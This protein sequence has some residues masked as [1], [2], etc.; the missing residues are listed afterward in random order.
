MLNLSPS[1]VLFP[2]QYG[3]DLESVALKFPLALYQ[4]FL[5]DLDGARLSGIQAHITELRDGGSLQAV[6]GA[7][8]QGRRAAGQGRQAQQAAG[9][10]KQAQQ[11]TGQGKKAQQA[12]SGAAAA[13]AAR[14]TASPEQ[15][16]TAERQAAYDPAAAAQRASVPAPASSERQQEQR[17][18]GAPPAAAPAAAAVAAA[19][20]AETSAAAA[21]RGAPAA[22]AA[23]P[24]APNAEVLAAA[25]GVL[26][27]LRTLTAAELQQGAC[28]G[29]FAVL[30]ACILTQA[31]LCRLALTTPC[32]L[33]R[34][35]P[36]PPLHTPCPSAAA[37][38]RDELPQVQVAQAIYAE[39]QAALA[40]VPRLSEV[41]PHG[42]GCL[43][44]CW[45]CKLGEAELAA[46]LQLCTCFLSC[47]KSSSPHCNLCALPAC[48]L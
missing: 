46:V 19:A 14:T 8:Q 18:R 11:A 2:S 13:A 15:P 10:G 3:N 5:S 41:R 47:N 33:F 27:Q 28:T 4:P 35:L 48:G 32:H 29:A 37:Y 31:G 7:G 9:Q 6:A 16:A 1:A 42:H 22:A 30:Q 21:A 40:A 43:L 17:S 24:P 12:G 36:K 26:Q 34:P 39:V 38:R 25:Q 20:M 23:V 45:W 44:C